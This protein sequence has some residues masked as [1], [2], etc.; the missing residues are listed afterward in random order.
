MTANETFM[1][2]SGF[3]PKWKRPMIQKDPHKNVI[4]SVNHDAYA[5]I[6]KY[7]SEKN[8]RRVETD[9]N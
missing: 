7:H 4:L 6:I 5:S 8:D 9:Y 2:R 3:C 1:R